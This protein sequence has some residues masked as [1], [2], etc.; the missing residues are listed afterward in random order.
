MQL[1]NNYQ[2]RW[3]NLVKT[4]DNYFE[5]HGD[6]NKDFS[7]CAKVRITSIFGD[8]V[9]DCIPC[10]SGTCA[11]RAQFPCKSDIAGGENCGRD[12]FNINVDAFGVQLNLGTGGISAG[13]NPAR[14]VAAAWRPGQPLRGGG[15]RAG[16]DLRAARLDASKVAPSSTIGS[17]GQCG[18]SKFDCGRYGKGACADKPFG[19]A[20]CG[21]GLKCVR[22]DANW[23]GCRKQ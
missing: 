6:A 13:F 20:K 4:I 16:V 23:W 17:G 11:G 10:S 22:N 18:G 19:S 14:A 12:G 2:G 7:P 9:E 1:W 5:Y 3:Q 21:K 8:T 15:L